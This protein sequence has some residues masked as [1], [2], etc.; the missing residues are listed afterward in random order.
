MPKWMFRLGVLLGLAVASPVSAGE[1]LPA[2]SPIEAV[3]DHYVDAG[4]VAAGTKAAPE[5]DDATIVRRSSLDLI[6]R[7]PTA[8]RVARVCRVD[9]PREAGQAGRPPDRLAGVRPPQADSLDAMMMAGVRGSLREYL[10]TASRE[11]RPWD[12]IFREVL[13]ANEADPALEGVERVPQRREPR[14]PTA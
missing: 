10:L 1:L 5:A 2:E 12:R 4:L 8:S 7:I 14:T 9:R 6:G 3:V 11:N 13:A